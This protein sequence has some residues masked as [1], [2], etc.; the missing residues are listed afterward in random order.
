M[1]NSL[2]GIYTRLSTAEEN[3]SQCQHTVI[4]TMCF[5]DRNTITHRQ[6]QTRKKMNRA[7]VRQDKIKAF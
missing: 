1:K 2:S 4:E 7:S 6:K 5:Y 3:I